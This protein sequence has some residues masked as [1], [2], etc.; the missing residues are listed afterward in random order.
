MGHALGLADN[1]DPN[2]VM[3]YQADGNTGTLDSNDTEGMQMLYGTATPSF[4]TPSNVPS[5]LAASE[6]PLN[7]MLQQ[8]I[9]AASTFHT[10][11][12]ALTSFAPPEAVVSPTIVAA[13]APQ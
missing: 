5:E 9:Q 6:A 8:M 10:Q 3:Y 4:A 7:S 12:A 2:S 13:Q 11:Q 1:T